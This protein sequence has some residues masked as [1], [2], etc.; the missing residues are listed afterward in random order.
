MTEPTRVP[1]GRGT[2]AALVDAADVPLIAGYNWY[3]HGNGHGGWYVR[4]YA[5]GSPK[6]H[7]WVYMHQVIAGSYADHVNG[8]GLDNRRVNLREATPSQQG[9][10]QSAR[11]GTS[12]YKG[13]HWSRAAR[14]WIA[15][16]TVNRKQRHLGCYADEA[17]AAR[18]YD[19]AAR[20]AWGDYARL[21]FPEGG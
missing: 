20:A 5:T 17:E 13:V 10:N 19:A 21:N 3:R 12:Q 14:A 4:G 16:I 6:P 8:D 15:K 9:A 18:A 7:R 11:T 1:L 2:Y